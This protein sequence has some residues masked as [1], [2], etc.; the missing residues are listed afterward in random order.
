[1]L[2]LPSLFR[3][4]VLGVGGDW[5]TADHILADRPEQSLRPWLRIGG[6][7][8]AFARLRSRPVRSNLGLIPI[9]RPTGSCHG[10]LVLL[11]GGCSLE[12]TPECG[13]CLISRIGWSEIIL[14]IVQNLVCSPAG[15]CTITRTVPHPY[16]DLHHKVF[17]S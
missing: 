14:H 7:G 12:D 16:Q 15:I 2:R 9:D 5:R 13:D 10:H 11:F 3:R 6:R 8:S 1:V 17:A 4:L